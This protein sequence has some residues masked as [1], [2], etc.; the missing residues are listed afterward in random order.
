[1]KKRITL[2]I[3]AALLAVAG[4]QAKTLRSY[5]RL[6]DTNLDSNFWSTST[7][8]PETGNVTC[9]VSGGNSSIAWKFSSGLDL[10]SYST[11]VF[12]IADPQGQDMQVRLNDNSEGFWDFSHKSMNTLAA[13]ETELTLTLNTLTHNNGDGDGALLNLTNIKTIEIHHSSVSG[14]NYT[15]EEIYLEKEVAD[16]AADYTTAPF[17]ME[18]SAIVTGDATYNADTW[19]VTFDHDWGANAGWTY[20][21]ALDMSAYSY[22]VVVPSIPLKWGEGKGWVRLELIDA[23]NKSF[24]HSDITRFCWNQAR[25]LVVDINGLATGTYKT[26]TYEKDSETRTA[27][28]KGTFAVGDDYDGGTITA[29]EDF[30]LKTSEISKIRF[31]AGGNGDEPLIISAVY[32]TNTKTDISSDGHG[33]SHYRANDEAG[34]WGTV[35]LP[36]DAA[37]CGAETYEVVGV[38][39]IESPKTLYLKQVRGILA[40]GKA[41]VYKSNTG[42]D[43]SFYRVGEEEA[44]SPVAGNLQGT[45]TGA[46]VPEDSY[47]LSGGKWKKMTSASP[48]TTVAPFK[49]YL[50]LTSSLVVPAEAR[51]NYIAFGLDGGETT[52]IQTVNGAEAV[53][54]F[55]TLSGQRVDRPVKGLYIKNGKKVLVGSKR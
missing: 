4:V 51:G 26:V 33:A 46:S 18:S 44:A 39:A 8:N 15:I 9:E 41:Y 20:E 42:Y 53:T 13:G 32:M 24:M 43:V 29:V 10:S 30:V 17:S 37:V 35:C 12:R 2:L 31:N 34:K 16:D 21:P 36:Y 50:T 47:I 28:S 11:L 5:L 22:L 45:F 55:Y 23:D 52:A 1:M 38:D 3:A 14:C 7:V 40:K 27:V 6:G 54:A 49:A 48:A 25:T 19:S